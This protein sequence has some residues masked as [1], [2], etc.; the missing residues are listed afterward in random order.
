MLVIFPFIIPDKVSLNK[1]E[2]TES[3]RAT[4]KNSYGESYKGFGF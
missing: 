2:K 4:P 1:K 3:R